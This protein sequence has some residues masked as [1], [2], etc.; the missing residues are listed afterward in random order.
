MLK[1]TATWIKVMDKQ[2]QLIVTHRRLY[3]D[4]KQ[5]SMEW[6]PYLT[7]ISRKPRSLFNSGLFDMMPDSMQRYMKL[8]S[9]SDRGT[10]LKVLAELTNRT[11]FDSAL[12]TVNQALLYQVKDPDS[13]KNLYRRLY[14]DVPELPL[15]PQQGGIPKIVQMPVDL[16]SYDRLLEKGGAANG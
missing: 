2:Q 1:I 4:Q 7:A 15:L 6:I 3:G 16:S 12:Q 9:S 11:G 14:M 13:L 5:S 10:I 8:C